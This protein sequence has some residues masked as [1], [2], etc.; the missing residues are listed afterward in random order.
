MEQDK[1]VTYGDAQKILKQNPGMTEK[2]FFEEIKA[3]FYIE[4][5]F[6]RNLIR[7][8]E[9]KLKK[10]IDCLDETVEQLY[11][12]QEDFGKIFKELHITK[13]ILDAFENNTLLPLKHSLGALTFKALGDLGRFYKEDFKI[14]FQF[15]QL[16][17]EM[18]HIS[19][20]LFNKNVK[21]K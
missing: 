19:E 6:E 17:F 12:K 10:G 15:C 16:F 8:I 9:S 13:E 7:H 2:M 20:D 18:D 3:N 5:E 21:K 4:I 11:K 14:T 1:K